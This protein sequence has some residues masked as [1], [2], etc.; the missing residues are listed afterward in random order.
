MMRHRLI[1]RAV[2]DR[3]RSGWF[4]TPDHWARCKRH[5]HRKRRLSGRSELAC[6]K[7][8]NNPIQRAER[9]PQPFIA[10]GNCRRKVFGLIARFRAWRK[11][12]ER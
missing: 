10:N 12:D 5:A 11:F 4:A 2:V 3:P 1:E 6:E 7:R 8:K 9:K